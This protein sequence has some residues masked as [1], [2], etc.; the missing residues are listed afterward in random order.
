MGP[1]TH[2]ETHFS[3]FTLPASFP[4]EQPAIFRARVSIA[5][6]LQAAID[7]EAHRAAALEENLDDEADAWEDEDDGPT[8]SRPATPLS[9]EPTPLSFD[10]TVPPSPSSSRSSSPLSDVPPSRPPSPPAAHHA[11]SSSS[12]DAAKQRRRDHDKA[13]RQRKRQAAAQAT[14]FGR[15][16]TAKHNQDYRTEKPC[17]TTFSATDIPSSSGGGWRAGRPTK[18]RRLVQRGIRRLKELLDD[19]CDLLKWEGH[20]PK[21]ILDA[22][23]R[24]VGVLIGRPEGADWDQ[25]IAE[26][27]AILEAL[28]KRGKKRGVFKASQRS[29]RR[30]NYYTLGH[31]TTKGPGQKKPGNLAHSKMYRE[32]LQVLLLNHNIRRI[33]GFQSSGLARYLPL[34]YQQLATT[35]RGIYDRQP[36]LEHLFSNSI[37]PAATW[38]LG[39]ATVTAEHEDVLNA[40]F[41][42]CAVTSAGKYDY[43]H[44]GHLYMKQLKLV[45]EFPPGS[46]ILLLSAAVTHGNTPIARGE[47]R[48]SMTQY[49]SGELFRWAEYGYQSGKTLLATK[50]GRA[51]K[52]RIDGGPGERA[53]RCMN[54]LSKAGSLAAD[55]Q[56]V[57]GTTA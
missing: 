45:I 46:T 57:F 15:P 2:G 30:G 44:G 36:E 48:Y 32:L 20:D 22:D 35:L 49:A 42:M 54:L 6:F 19:D 17:K 10:R 18:R 14:Q 29:H 1:T 43:K 24:I 41:L 50:E 26:M 23:D 7:A 9:R 25:V 4:D 3:P 11:P 12:V 27:A 40:P 28:R 56:A 52:Q 55:R 53:E 38:N 21:L 5:P 37:F 47:T 33:A 31:G 16:P 51:M 39:P 8:L 13:R 34:L